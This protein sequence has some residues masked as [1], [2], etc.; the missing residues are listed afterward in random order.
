MKRIKGK[1]NILM[2]NY[3]PALKEIHISNRHNNCSKFMTNLK[4][5]LV[6]YWRNI[7]YY[8]LLRQKKQHCRMM[9]IT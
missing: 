3:Y 2:D 9:D 7:P 6:N 5:K 1:I 4:D 8:Q